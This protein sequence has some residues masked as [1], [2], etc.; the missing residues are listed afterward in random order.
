VRHQGRSSVVLPLAAALSGMTFLVGCGSGSTGHSP[1][2]SLSARPSSSAASL[3]GQSAEQIMAEAIRAMRAAGSVHLVAHNAA[4][5]K[6]ITFIDDVSAT[7][8]RE[9]IRT[10]GGGRA[11]FLLIAGVGYLRGN[12]AALENYYGAPARVAARLSGRWISFHHSDR[13]YQRLT[14]QLTLSGFIHEISLEAPLVRRGSGLVGNQPAVAVQGTASAASGTPAGSK[15]TLY[16]ASTGCPLPLSLEGDVP[17]TRLRATF[18]NWGEA[19][20]LA[21]PPNFLPASSLTS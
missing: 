16:I 7:T 4:G 21:P 1:R 6:I 14:S 10:N 11:T 2:P 12:A 8:S 17:G 3:A 15:A 5:S 20:H 13:D 19:L 9:V 18:S